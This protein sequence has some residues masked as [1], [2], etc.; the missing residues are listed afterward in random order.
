M[1]HNAWDHALTVTGGGAGLVGH[2]DVILLRK[3]ADQAGLTAGRGAALR[4]A[5]MSPVLDRGI[6]L[7]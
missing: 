7:A 1:E 6:V 2:A 5:G 3:A 4:T